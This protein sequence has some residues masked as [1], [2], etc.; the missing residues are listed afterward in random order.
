MIVRRGGTDG[1]MI[2][3]WIGFCILCWATSP[4]APAQPTGAALALLREWAGSQTNAYRN[5]SEVEMREE[6]VR[7][8]E[9]AF[10]ERDVQIAAVLRGQPGRRGWQRRVLSAR[11]DGRDLPSDRRRRFE[12][13][14][15]PSI[16]DR[17]EELNDLLFLPPV[18]TTGLRQQRVPMPTLLDGIP[19]F[20]YDMAPRNRAEGPIRDVSLWIDR[21]SAR[22]LRARLVLERPNR[23]R[24]VLD[25][26]YGSLGDL[27]IPLVRRVEATIQTKRRLRTFT[28][29]IT[30]IS[31]YTEHRVER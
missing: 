12:Q 30:V 6:A 9:G 17:M 15:G 14:R 8:V 4:A 31:D 26:Q 2:R 18:L 10:A 24:I 3:T 27:D 20:R 7:T 28:H 1:L 11:V 22:L 13:P 25:T 16:E 21:D 19:A 5:V 23:G 29:F